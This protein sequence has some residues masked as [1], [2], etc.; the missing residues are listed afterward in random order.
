MT[1]GARRGIEGGLRVIGR[2]ALWPVRRFVDPRIAGLLQYLDA[3]FAHINRRLDS[4]EGAAFGGLAV[5]AAAEATTLMGQSLADL[6]AQSE[7]TSARLQHISDSVDR[8]ASEMEHRA[9]YFR[10]LSEAP[11]EDLDENAAGFL[12][13]ALGHR[14]FAAQ[15]G[16][17]FN[18]PISLRHG[19]G[20]VEVAQINERI[21]EIPYVFR[22]L[23]RLAPGAAILDVGAAESTLSMSL[24]TLGYDVVALDPRGY[25]LSH[26]R[27]EGVRSRIDEW[28]YDGTFDAIVCLS[29]IEHI[30]LASYGQPPDASEGDVAAMRRMHELAK[31]GAVLVLTTSFGRA[32][33]DS[34]TR[35]YDRDGLGALLDGWS[36]EDM[37]FVVHPSPTEW[38]LVSE[39]QLPPDP[40]EAVVL[41]TANRSK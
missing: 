23:S 15:H 20:S 4:L 38:Q 8:L 6:L 5:D 1:V 14:G 19:E 11:V 25:P 33:A 17:W 28:A 12:N 40:I 39:D 18:P 10:R 24:A 35:T 16:L 41:V 29:T 21:V 2:K 9:A 3:R 22:A 27:L 34:F 36:V 32:K 37:S 13:A 30:G 7:E 26:P 31:P